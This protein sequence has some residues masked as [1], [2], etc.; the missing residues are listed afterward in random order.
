MKKGFQRIACVFLAVTAVI[1]PSCKKEDKGFEPSFGMKAFETEDPQPIRFSIPLQWG[2]I[3]DPSSSGI[4]VFA[5][6]EA[7]QGGSF[8]NVSVCIY[9][10]GSEQAPEITDVQTSFQEGF[11]TKVKE[12]YAQAAGFVY[13]VVEMPLFQVF[14]AEY[15]IPSGDMNLKQKVYYPLT[16]NLQIYVAAC[17]NGGEGISADEVAQT[18]LQTLYLGG[19]GEE[20]SSE[21]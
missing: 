11:E 4:L 18:I 19:N 13:E 16:K 10:S 3:A 20:A 6:E 8:N 1:L 21:E 14:T 12:Q 5:G 17:D 2:Q 9:P 7:Y 15:T